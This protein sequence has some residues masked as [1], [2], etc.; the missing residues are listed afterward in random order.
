MRVEAAKSAGTYAPR[1]A[2]E[3]KG[4]TSC[5]RTTTPRLFVEGGYCRRPEGDRTIA[6]YCSADHVA[7]PNI[8]HGT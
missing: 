8:G 1:K 6:Q 4:T 2:H 5:P 7:D 3:S